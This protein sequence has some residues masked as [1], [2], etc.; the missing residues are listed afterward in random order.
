MR[1]FAN[2]ILSFVLSGPVAVE[3]MSG[4]YLVAAAVLESDFDF[5]GDANA[6]DEEG[7][8]NFLSVG[9]RWSDRLSTE[10]AYTDANDY[11]NQQF[12]TSQVDMWEVAAL[13]HG[14]YAGQF[15]PYF[16]LYA[17]RAEFRENWTEGIRGNTSE[18]LLWGLGLA[19]R[20]TPGGV[21]RLDYAPCSFGGDDLD[22]LM[23]GA[24]LQ[25]SD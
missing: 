4:P 13:I 22:R 7:S 1:L 11:K 5:A 12:G 20:L 17:Y 25:F 10:L 18:G 6:Q 8:G 23:L 16:R 19:Y 14:G 2:L 3:N 15:D 9:Y 21:V 24:V